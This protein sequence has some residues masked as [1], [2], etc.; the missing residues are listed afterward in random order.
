[1]RITH[2]SDLEQKQDAVEEVIATHA[3]WMRETHS[4]EADGRIHFVDYHVA[5]AEEMNDLLDSSEGKTGNIR[6][7]SMKFMLR[8]TASTNIWEKQ[9]NGSTF[10][11]S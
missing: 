6:T 10:R 8:M 5:K 1:M 2:Q 3:A 9:C 4:L 11:I 7:Q